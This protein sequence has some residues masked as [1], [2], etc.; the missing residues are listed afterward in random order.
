MPEENS[1]APNENMS[2]FIFTIVV[3]IS[4]SWDALE[5]SKFK[6]SLSTSDFGIHSK[7]SCLFK[8]F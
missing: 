1:P 3:G 7:G 5:T 6:M 8:F 4:E 2:A